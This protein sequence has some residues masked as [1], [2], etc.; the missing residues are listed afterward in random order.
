VKV[1]WFARNETRSQVVRVDHGRLPRDL[2]GVPFG[3]PQSSRNTL[4]ATSE[5]TVL[6]SCSS[7]ELDIDE[8]LDSRSSLFIIGPSHQQQAIAPLMAGLVDSIAQ[9]ASELAAKRG[10]RLDPPLMPALDEV[11]NIAPLQ[12]LPSLVSEGGFEEEGGFPGKQVGVG[13]EVHGGS[14]RGVQGGEGAGCC[15]RERP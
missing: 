5:P 12:S 6:A 2:A 9:R 14:L 3:Q 13:A 10:G 8:F 15:R 11:A 1:Q 4:E 7:N